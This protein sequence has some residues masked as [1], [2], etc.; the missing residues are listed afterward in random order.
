M[1]IASS[2]GPSDVLR[3]LIA[4]FGGQTTNLSGGLGELLNALSNTISAT[5]SIPYVVG[6]WYGCVGGATPYLTPEGTLTATPFRALLGHTFTAIGANTTIVGTAGA[7][8]RTGIYSDNGSAYPGNLIT[9]FGSFDATQLGIIILP[10]NQS[11][12]A[13]LYW[14][15]SCAQGTPTTQATYSSAA[16]TGWGVTPTLLGTNSLSS[17]VYSVGY[18]NPAALETFLPTTFPPSGSSMINGPALPLLRLQA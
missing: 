6:Q 10:I 8:L 4:A 15:V 3:E 7:T 17:T 9:E 5:V 14:L 2:Y 18:T 13:G 11:L 1:T 12:A 16:A